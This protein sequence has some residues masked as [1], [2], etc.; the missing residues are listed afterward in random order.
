MIHEPY[1]LLEKSID[2]Y[3][4]PII[5]A[6]VVEALLPPLPTAATAAQANGVST[7]QG[8]WWY[9]ATLPEFAVK[10]R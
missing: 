7:P 4:Q 1:L 3:W 5:E 2:A 8:A 9:V 10:P 6:V